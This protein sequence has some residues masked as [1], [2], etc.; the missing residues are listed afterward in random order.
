M[1]K[2]LEGAITDEKIRLLLN[3]LH[4]AANGQNEKIMNE[5]GPLFQQ[6]QN[7][8]DL[9]WDEIEQRLDDKYISLDPATG[10]FCYLFARAIRAR[11]IIEFGTSFG[12]STIYLGMAVRDNGGGIVIGTEMV[13]KK[14][15]QAS[16]NIAAAGLSEF[17]DIRV[18]NALETLRDVQGPVD[19]FLN[20]GFVR[21][22][23]PV[24]KMVAPHIR[25]GGAVIT[26]KV[27][28]SDP[29][30]HE[31]LKY[32]R[33]PSNDFQSVLLH[34][35]ANSIRELEAISAAPKPKRGTL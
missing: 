6:A 14:A 28:E 17:V 18:G 26:D 32:V 9:A 22:L 19:F 20:D 16:E 23:L 5:L 11:R 7:D 2:E 8:R 24:F 34:S 33:D 21:K 13:G 27:D 29:V 10:V 4:N 25:V 31:Y 30:Y 15:R 1:I 35:N 12:I 3:S